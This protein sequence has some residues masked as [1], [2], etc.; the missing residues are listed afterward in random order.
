MRLAHSPLPSGPRCAPRASRRARATRGRLASIVCRSCSQARPVR[1]PPHCG[2]SAPRAPLP[3]WLDLSLPLSVFGR[4][5][6]RLPSRCLSPALALTASAGSAQLVSGRARGRLCEL[7]GQSDLCSR[8]S[9]LG[10]GEGAL[11]CLLDARPKDAMI[12]AAAA[13]LPRSHRRAERSPLGGVWR[14]PAP[15]VDSSAAPRFPTQLRFSWLPGSA[16][17]TQCSTLPGPRCVLDAD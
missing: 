7:G 16:F 1:R 14:R 15:R 2:I 17:F 3:S 12:R 10:F 4:S 9:A 11:Q 5:A 8:E 6:L 13:R